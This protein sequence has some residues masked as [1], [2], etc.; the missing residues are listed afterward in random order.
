MVWIPQK[1]YP[2]F[3]RETLKDY[4]YFTIDSEADLE[5]KW[6]LLLNQRPDFIKTHLRFSDEHEKRKGD[7][8]YFG[9]K[10]L[11]PRLLPKIVAKAHAHYLRVS[12]HV[13]NATDFHNALAAGFDEI[14]HLPLT[15]LTSITVEDARLRLAS[16]PW[17]YSV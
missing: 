14:T 10:G 17:V 4:R 12:T 16:P 6:P 2:G 11:D 1:L 15:G 7:Q 9:R 8:A 13:S 5:K 3:T